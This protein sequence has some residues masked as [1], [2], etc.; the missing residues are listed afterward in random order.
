[1]K[2]LNAAVALLLIAYSQAKAQNLSFERYQLSN[3]MTVILHEDHSLPVATIN[4]WF[5]VGSKDEEPGRSGFAHL[6]EHLMFMGTRR[7]PG[8]AFDVIMERGGG[9]NNASTSEDRTNYFSF[10]PSSLLPT[11]LW[12]DADRLEDLGKEMTQEKLDKQRE[13]VRNERRQ[14]SEMQ[15]YGRADLKIGE[16]MYPPNHPYHHTVI[17]SHEDLEAATLQDVKDFFARYYVPNNACLVIAGDFDPKEIKP[18]VGQLFGTM[19][20]GGEPPHFKA[21][22]VKLNE[23]RRVT[24]TDN[25]QFPRLTYVYHSPA[26]FA[27]GDAEMDL[28]AGVLGDGKSSRLYKKLVY[29]EKLATDVSANQYSSFLGSLFQVEVTARPDASQERIEELTDEVLSAFVKDGPTKD[30]L[31]RQKTAHEFSTVSQL[32]SLL[33]RA[34]QLN[35]YQFYL[36]TP[37][38]LKLDLARYRMPSPTDVRDWA[39]KVLTPTGRL[40]MWVL[41][42][43]SATQIV[44]ARDK[45]PAATEEKPFTP[46]APEHFRAGGMEVNFWRRPE[47]PLVHVSVMLRGGAAEDAPDQSGRTYLAANMLDEGAGNLDALQFADSLDQLGARMSVSA[48]QEFVT[49]NLT[50]L[51]KNFDESLSLFADAIWRPSMSEKEWDRVK[52]LHIEGLKQ[53]EDR[54][55]VVA[56]RVGL[57]AFFG[58]ENPYGRPQD[59]SVDSVAKL[60]LKDV[61]ARCLELVTP[62]R[63]TFYVAGDLTREEVEKSLGKAFAAWTPGCQLSANG[64]D[65]K[66]DE[67]SLPKNSFKPATTLG[68]TESAGR[69]MRVVIVDKP[70]AVQTVI[71]FFMPGPKYTTPDR[72]RLEMLNTILGGSFTSRLNQNLREDKGY[73]YGARSSFNMAP[74]IGYFSAGADVQAE[75]TG[76][77]LKEFYAEFKRLRGGDVSAEETEKARESNRMEVVQSFQG[78]SGLVA[79]A[80][81]LDQNG[82][83]FS[84]LGDD[85]AK[86][87][88]IKADDLNSIASSAI[89]LDQALLVLVGNRKLIESQIGDLDL[90]T[91]EQ[92]TAR[93]ESVADSGGN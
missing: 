35:E 54:A 24:Y 10:G 76:A 40:I 49:L 44:Q 18:L 81:L 2:S 47:L 64:A 75:H 48:G 53:A 33:R 17:G 45:Q 51:K 6:F 4:T 26:N 72:V 12:L 9:W 92:L 85:L 21:D 28:A 57:R 91:P 73:T 52:R 23:I 83:P 86:M 31:E 84:T 65:W 14:T 30:E 71:R 22:P 60:T 87:S 67:L 80:E 59:G 82:L 90:P 78:L 58:D 5:Y 34:D 25:V 56:A 88:Q 50:G 27:E 42:E 8:N 63:A 61:R 79:T 29:D 93:G 68:V 38:G 46:Q 16:L 69:K 62:S 13:V 11:L 77:A 55:T 41:P 1:M 32:E 19:P 3:G 15:P 74:A 43:K 20:R 7:V 37:D 36:G 66:G 89:P 39:K 70:D